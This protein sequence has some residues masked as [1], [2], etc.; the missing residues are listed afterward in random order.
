MLMLVFAVADVQYAMPCTHVVEVIPRV[1]LAVIPHAP[2]FVV[3]TLNFR[4]TPVPVID[5]SLMV[6][7]DPSAN[8][9]H[10]RI[11]VVNV[12]LQ[13]KE[14]AQFAIVAEKVTE[15]ANYELEQ[16]I[17]SGIR[18]AELPFLAGVMTVDT[19][20]WQLIDLERLAEVIAPV[21]FASRNE[22]KG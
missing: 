8:R 14:P 12:P 22:E 21:V 9:L 3:G 10:T 6:G 11:I 19:A 13:G 17:D 18:V 15:T 5:L 4:G 16:F 2:K 20:T 7:D 1:D